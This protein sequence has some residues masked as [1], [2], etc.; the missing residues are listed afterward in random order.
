LLLLLLHSRRYPPLG[1]WGYLLWDNLNLLS[2]LYLFCLFFLHRFYYLFLTVC[3]YCFI[4]WLT[5]LLSWL[6]N[7][8]LFLFSLLYPSR[9]PLFSW[10][11]FLLH[12]SFNWSN[13]SRFPILFAFILFTYIF[14]FLRILITYIQVRIRWPSV[15]ILISYYVLYGYSK[16]I[17]VSIFLTII[18]STVQVNLIL[19][20]CLVYTEKLRIIRL[21]LLVYYLSC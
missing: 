20:C 21:I 5:L 8:W 7:R 13:F 4:Y 9:L 1:L 15:L 18:T 6:L 14:S 19:F 12:F 3:Y 2:T 11:L 16:R 10:F 17:S